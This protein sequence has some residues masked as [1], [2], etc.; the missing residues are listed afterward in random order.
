M[1]TATWP[2]TTAASRPAPRRSAARARGALRSAGVWLR[3][4][5]FLCALWVA[6]ECPD[7]AFCFA[8]SG[9]AAGPR[10]DGAAFANHKAGGVSRAPFVDDDDAGDL[11]ADAPDTRLN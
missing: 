1:R 11:D 3:L 4:L 7:G 5:L 6:W 2:G 8:V 9:T 10:A